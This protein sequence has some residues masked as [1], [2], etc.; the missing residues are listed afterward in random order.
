MPFGMIGAVMACVLAAAVELAS[1]VVAPPPPSTRG[2]EPYRPAY[3]ARPA[4]SFLQ[5]QEIA[6]ARIQ[7]LPRR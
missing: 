3:V 2:F 5:T 7:L 4:P 1:F 6:S